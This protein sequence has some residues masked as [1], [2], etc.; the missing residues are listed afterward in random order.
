MSRKIVFTLLLCVAWVLTAGAQNTI[1][2][3]RKAYQDVHHMIDQMTPDEGGMWEMPP[4]YYDLKVVQNLPGT[5]PHQEI[6]RMFYGDLET[7][8]EYDPYPPHYLQSARKG[9]H[10][11]R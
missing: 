2:S 10:D 6:I 4:E 11:R 1:E 9:S 8:E 5:G 7:E 3:I